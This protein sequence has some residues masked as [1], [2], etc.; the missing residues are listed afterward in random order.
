MQ[1][2]LSFKFQH[3]CSKPNT[4][5]CFLSC[6]APDGKQAATALTSS[7]LR[8]RP[9]PRIQISKLKPQI[10]TSEFDTGACGVQH[11]KAGSQ[12]LEWSAKEHDLVL[13]LQHAAYPPIQSLKDEG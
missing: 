8:G 1:H 13:A 9:G 10:S 2:S 4:S 3:S 7:S 6:A 11:E 12:L 5:W